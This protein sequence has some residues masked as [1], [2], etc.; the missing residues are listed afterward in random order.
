MQEPEKEVIRT[1]RDG[2]PVP[3]QAFVSIM[4]RADGAVYEAVVSVDQREVR[5]FARIPDVQAPFLFEEFALADRLIRKHPEWRAAIRRRGI[6]DFDRVRIDPWFIGNFGIPEEQGRRMVSSLAYLREHNE[7]N[8]YA[9]PIEGVLAYVDLVQARVV[10]VVDTGVV[11]IPE[12]PGRY[13]PAATGT[14]SDLRPIA[15][16]Q[17]QGPSFTLDGWE[18]RW[19]RWRL[20]VSFNAREGLVLHTVGYED[21]DR[22]RPILYRAGLSEMV[23]PYG[24]VSPAHFY[25]GAFDAGDYGVGKGVN[26]LELGCDCLGEIRYLDVTLFDDSGEPVL[27]PKAICIHEEDFGLLWKHRDFPDGGTQT[28]RSRRLVVSSISTLLNYEYGF[29]WYFYQDGTIEFQVKLT[30]IVQTAAV[31]ESRRPRHAELVAPGLSAMHHQHLFNLRLDMEVDGPLNSVYEVDVETMPSGAEN[32]FDTGMVVKSTLLASEQQAQRLIDP[33]A[34][35]RWLV[36]NESARNAVDGPTGYQLIPTATPTLLARPGTAL[37]RRAAFARKNLWVTPFDPNER[38]AGGPYPNQHPG[39]EG[40]PKW[41]AGNRPLTNADIVLWHT[42]GVTHV[43]RPEDWPVMPVEYTGFLLKPCGFF[44]R[45][46]AL[47]VPPPEG[48]CSP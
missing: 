22:V 7:D 42:F 5:S 12:D 38:Y 28:R 45:N 3:R 25:Q 10:K 48:H 15:I 11:P 30:G 43:V 14:R 33:A 34:S 9:R 27:V 1:F 32:P 41:T 4:D 24:D 16:T 31:D 13:D 26:A 47:D 40:L 18:L 35:R 39:G 46:P 6:T 20:R 21:Q 8:P 17:P 23:V 44:R 36:V 37:A 29:F 2:D 19:Q